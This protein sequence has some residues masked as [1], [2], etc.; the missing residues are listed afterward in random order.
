M[1]VHRGWKR[2]VANIVFGLFLQ[3]SHLSPTER[4]MATGYFSTKR[5][6]KKKQQMFKLRRLDP[7]M[8]FES[9]RQIDNLCA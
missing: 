2:V 4:S 9:K 7:D 5:H 6:H 8:R 1:S 3:A